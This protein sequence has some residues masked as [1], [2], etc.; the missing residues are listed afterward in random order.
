[1]P[2]FILKQLSNHRLVETCISSTKENDSYSLRNA[3]SDLTFKFTDRRELRYNR[4]DVLENFGLILSVKIVIG[5]TSSSAVL[6]EW[7]HSVE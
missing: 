6:L 5:E 4:K 2:G 3:N 7:L 1:M